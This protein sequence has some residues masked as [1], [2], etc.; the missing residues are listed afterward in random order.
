MRILALFAVMAG[1]LLAQQTPAVWTLS[2]EP[3]LRLGGPDGMGPTEFAGPYDAA[4]W[5]DRLVV[6]DGATQSLRTFS[7]G[8][9]RHRGTYGRKGAGPGEYTN[10]AYLQPFAGDSL[11]VSDIQ[12]SRYTI[13]DSTGRVA[14]TISFATIWPGARATPLG[15]LADGSILAWASRFDAAVGPGSHQIFTTIL[16]VTADGKRADSLRVLPFTSA[17]PVSG[18]WRV[19][20]GAGQLHAAVGGQAAY[21]NS[22][23]KY[24]LYVLRQDGAWSTIEQSIPARLA[25][26]NDA[27]AIRQRAVAQGAAPALMA[28][29]EMVDTLPAIVI[30]KLSP[31]GRLFVFDA[32]IDSARNR[33]GVTVY[34]AGK[35]LARFFMPATLRILAV[36][37]SQIAVT[38]HDPTDAPS[39]LVYSV[40]P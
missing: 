29:V 14:R 16:R 36:S 19:T 6:L 12:Q 24:L 33:R 34:V 8:D 1:P 11:F 38:E 31:A 39:I 35:A 20:F 23:T 15:R 25:R 17:Q 22:P 40:R 26:P 9:G 28:Q 32:P 2:P 13:L 18:G 10:A 4:F 3:T 27:V 21:F 7:L 5:G 37:D 30:A